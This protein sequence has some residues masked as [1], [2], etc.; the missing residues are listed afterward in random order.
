MLNIEE[1]QNILPQRFPFLMIDKIVELEPGKK[2]VAIKNVSVNEQFFSGHFPGRPVM[3]GVLII[4]AM[5]QAAIILF[6]STKNIPKDKKM[7]YYLG[8]VKM[9]F[10]H[11][12]FPGDQLKIIVKPIK[13][14]SNIG[15]VNVSAEAAG[16]EVARGELS[17]SAKEDSL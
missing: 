12:V 15:I 4:E 16:K 2:V 13:M 1:I 10:L 3:P 14:L 17:L 11:P 7:S 5:A 6:S 8:S 9:R